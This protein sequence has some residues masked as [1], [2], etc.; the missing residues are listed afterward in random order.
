MRYADREERQVA[1]D[2]HWMLVSIKRAY[3]KRE[4]S[5]AIRNLR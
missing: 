1:S 2:D 3:L 4:K 5:D